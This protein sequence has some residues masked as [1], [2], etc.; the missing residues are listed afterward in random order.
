M[1]SA[2]LISN[3]E[4]PVQCCLGG[5]KLTAREFVTGHRRA[6]TNGVR[7]NRTAVTLGDAIYTKYLLIFAVEYC[8]VMSTTVVVQSVFV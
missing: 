3:S 5:E 1:G 2:K 8:P 6:G 7:N 4:N